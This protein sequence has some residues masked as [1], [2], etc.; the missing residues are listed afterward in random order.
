MNH[1]K[2]EEQNK[3]ANE[4]KP[5][6]ERDIRKRTLI[7]FFLLAI[8]VIAIILVINYRQKKET[9]LERPLID[10][11]QIS[12]Q[13]F[14]A[15]SGQPPV[16]KL[17]G[18]WHVKTMGTPLS[19][20]KK[21]HSDLHKDSTAPI[22]RSPYVWMW[23]DPELSF[24]ENQKMSLELGDKTFDIQEPQKR[25]YVIDW[26]VTSDGMGQEL[27]ST[28]RWEFDPKTKCSSEE[29][30]LQ[31]PLEAPKPRNEKYIRV[32]VHYKHKY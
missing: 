14:K 5:K 16:T 21:F 25:C 7:G 8:L 18:W 28:D 10:S 4:S 32:F 12:A 19:V 13:D 11:S 22:G 27:E 1:S 29:E 15:L 9:R 26:I 3:Q 20:S 2:L 31:L 23:V 24:K 6:E 30:N 17:E